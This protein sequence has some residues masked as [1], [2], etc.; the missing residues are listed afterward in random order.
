[1]L[2]KIITFSVN[3]KLIIDL[4][5]LGL[6]GYGAYRTTQLPIDA[7]PDITNNQV[8]YE[9]VMDKAE[10]G[11]KN[12]GFIQIKNSGEFIEK[13]LVTIGAYTL[14]MALKNKEEEHCI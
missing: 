4:F 10:I 7:V 14:L 9:F 11:L 8:K 2:N 1:M 13:A 12:D 5:V 6:I 3:N